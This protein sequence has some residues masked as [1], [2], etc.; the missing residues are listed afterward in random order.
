MTTKRLTMAQAII[1]FLQNQYV[2][3]DGQEKRF[4]RWLLGHFWTWECSGNWTSATAIFR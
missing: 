2:E 4:F 1:L 3:R